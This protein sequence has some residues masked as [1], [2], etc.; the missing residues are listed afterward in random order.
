MKQNKM[1]MSAVGA[2]LISGVAIAQSKLTLRNESWGAFSNPTITS[3]SVAT[4]GWALT[5]GIHTT[6]RGGADNY[7]IKAFA[8]A[9]TNYNVG[10]YGLADSA[11][12]TG[13]GVFGQSIR[14]VS[15]NYGVYGQASGGGHQNWA[16]YF[17]GSVYTTGTYQPSDVKLKRNIKTEASVLDKVMKLR[18]VSY[19]YKTDEMKH[20]SLPE[21]TQHGFVAQELQQVFPEMVKE[22]QQLVIENN[23]IAKTEDFTAVNY[24]ALI[25]VL[26]KAIQEQ[27]VMIEDLKKQIS[28]L[29]GKKVVSLYDAIPNPADASTTIRYSLPDDV[30][31][32]SIEVYDL[33]GKKLMQFNN[34]R[35]SS[36]ITVNSSQLAAGTYVYT[37][38]VGGKAAV[39]NKFLVAKG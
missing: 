1:L 15:S 37:L 16:G 34:L 3:L 26:I 13:V 9:G 32:A 22:S 36:Q 20:M 23:K 19:E 10:V 25:P 30:Q 29:G 38:F 2:L 8:I 35:G 17:V 27:Q 31:K 5:E 6:G 33:A 4:G 12:V 14:G 24:T 18:P 39:S 28:E 7:G 11:G 21:K